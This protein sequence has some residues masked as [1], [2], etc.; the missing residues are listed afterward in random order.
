MQVSKRPKS[1]NVGK[2]IGRKKKEV[3][4]A[5]VSEKTAIRLSL[6]GGVA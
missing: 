5:Y 1:G 4:K 6:G 2:N 3:G